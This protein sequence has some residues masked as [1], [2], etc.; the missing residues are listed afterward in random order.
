MDSDPPP[1]TAASQPFTDD[2]TAADSGEDPFSQHPFQ[3]TGSA[4]AGVLIALLALALPLASVMGDRPAQLGVD[5][6][7]LGRDG[8]GNGPSRSSG[9]ETGAVLTLPATLNDGSRMPAR[10]T[11]PRAG[12]SGGGDSRRQP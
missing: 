5:G 1:R 11:R 9:T 4:L 7:D 8:S 10:L 12:E 3:A 2:S 6:G